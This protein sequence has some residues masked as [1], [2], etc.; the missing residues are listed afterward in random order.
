MK[1]KVFHINENNKIEFTREELEK[2]LNDTYAEGFNDCEKTHCVLCVT[3][4]KDTEAKDNDVNTDCDRKC[5]E[6][7]ENNCNNHSIS[8]AVEYDYDVPY[9][10]RKLV[11]TLSDMG[12]F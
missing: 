7:R 4:A 8:T 11:K 12:G 10:V 5:D 3:E 1:I 2:L 9:S 6:K